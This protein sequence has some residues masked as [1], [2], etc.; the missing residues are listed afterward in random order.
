MDTPLT[1][2]VHPPLLSLKTI[3]HPPFSTRSSHSHLPYAAIC[4]VKSP[5]S[6]ADLWL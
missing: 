1:T 2:P 4:L 6:S 3:P 5:L